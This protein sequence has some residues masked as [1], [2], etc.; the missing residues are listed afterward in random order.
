VE[1]PTDEAFEIA[2]ILRV[3]KFWARGEGLELTLSGTGF[4]RVEEAL[5][6]PLDDEAR[7]QFAD[8]AGGEL[9]KLHSLRSSSALVFN[10]FAPW[11]SDLD[12]LARV[13]GGAGTCDRLRFERPYP[14]GVSPRHPHLDVILD[15]GDIPIA[16]ESKFCEIYDPPKPAEFSPRYWEA[17][18]LWAGIP[19][20]RALAGELVDKPMTF[21]R[22]G[23]AQLIKHVLG[24]AR[25]YG[26]AGFR[27]VY[28]WYDF[29][30]GSAEQH[31]R[32]VERF[33]EVAG[34]VIAFEAMTYQDLHRKTI[35]DRGARAGVSAVPRRAVRARMTEMPRLIVR[36]KAPE[37]HR[38]SKQTGLLSALDPDALVSEYHEMREQA[39]HRGLDGYRYFVERTGRPPQS[40]D[41]R[42]GE[43]RLSMALV[44]DGVSLP[45]GAETIDVLMYEFPLFT[46]GGKKGVRAVDLVGHAEGTNRFWV[47][48]L[49]VPRGSGYGETPLRAL[50]ET[51]IYAAVVE[52]NM[53]HIGAELEGLGR[54]VD[55][56]RPGLLVAAPEPYWRKW[57]PN[58]RIGNWWDLYRSVA[59]ALGQRLETPLETVSLGEISYMITA[60]RRP[61]V[62]GEVECR[63]VTYL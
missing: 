53:E 12:T 26:P 6:H 19:N 60:D 5:L 18:H 38:A 29:A 42:R 50:Y 15:G 36:S 33:S 20:L 14:T 10:V 51:L 23:A 52:A 32:E 63:K 47:A 58:P 49:K 13:L 28:L 22:L 57:T 7:Q 24:L 16:V 54:R 2:H 44:N 40:D 4:A 43:E 41:E 8:G 1:R 48:E 30:S 45:V 37:I 9:A 11:Q 3:G 39:P 56:E 61:R 21:Q 35:E 59:E 55:F 17:D 34:Q 46:T 25:E 62:V 27:L 31:R